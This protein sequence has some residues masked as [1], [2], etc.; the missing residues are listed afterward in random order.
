MEVDKITQII[1]SLG[2]SA[3]FVGRSDESRIVLIEHELG[4]TLPDT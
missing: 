2:T 1:D 4:V 3:R